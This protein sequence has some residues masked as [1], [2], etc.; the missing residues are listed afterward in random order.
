MSGPSSRMLTLLSLLQVRRDWAGDSLA[1]RLGVSPRT[2]R[3]DVDRLR[4]L[5]YRIDAVRGPAGGYRLGSGSELPPLLFD[6]E[7]AVAV[8]LAL[9]VAPASGA[10]IADAAVRA[11][12]TVRQT[13][14]PRLRHRVDSVQVVPASGGVLV[15]PD[16]LVGVSDATR[17]HEVLRFSYDSADGRRRSMRVEPHAVVA[18]DRRWYLLAWNDR[19]ARSEDDAVGDAVGDWRTYRMDRVV[20]GDPTHRTFVPREIPGGGDAAAF[21]A[22]RFKGS[23]SRDVWPCV[24]TAIVGLPAHRVS[25]F[26]DADAEIVSV[27][28][29]RTSVTMGSWSWGALAARFA[30]FDAA[31]EIVGPPE[32]GEAAGAVA[33][34]LSGGDRL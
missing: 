27:G 11:L 24:G 9:A 31:F 3:R 14:P 15:A 10:A 19:V 26:V 30:G 5:G 8:A 33:R 29:D 1:R 17:R 4:V 6:D 13:M 34:R 18:H 12:A 28:D 32:L 16:V 20:L 2:V 22:A 23:E 21:V 7:Q 25:P